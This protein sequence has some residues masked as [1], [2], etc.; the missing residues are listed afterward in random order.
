MAEVYEHYDKKLKDKAKLEAE[1]HSHIVESINNI[2]VIKALSIENKIFERI[3]TKIVNTITKGIK[4][5]SLKNIQ[6]T[7]NRM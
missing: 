2:S 6:N 3:E 5:G 7:I 4:L 1:K